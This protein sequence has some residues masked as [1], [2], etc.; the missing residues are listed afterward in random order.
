MIEKILL[1]DDDARILETF[2][3]YL[4][5]ENYTVITT[6][7]SKEAFQLYLTEQPQV[8]FTDVRMPPPDGF[9]ILQAIHA[10][11]PEAEVILITGHGDMDLAINALRAGASDFIPKPFDPD[12]VTTALYRARERLRLKHELQTANQALVQYARE[13]ETQNTELNRYNHT[14][15]Y[16]LQS[17]LHLIIGYAELLKEQYPRMPEDFQKYLNA[18]A[19]NGRRMHQIIKE[20]LLLTEARKAKEIKLTPLNMGRIVAEVKQRL[21]Y[22]IEQSHAELFLP[23]D[24]PM[25]MGY[26][27]WV[28]EVW[29]NYISN[30]IEY[31]GRPPRLQLGAT[32]QSSGLVRFW[33]RDNG[34]ELTEQERTR[35]LSALD[36]GED[37]QPA[38]RGLGLSIVRH[39]VEKLGGQVAIENNGKF[40]QG[41]TFSFTLVGLSDDH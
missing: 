34:P 28:E 36:L 13:L 26:A 6:S 11:A 1:I 29:A 30:A 7:N 41:N 19:R 35:L 31:G 38:G 22:M 39:I 24:W 32:A 15:A 8:V 37:I 25:A 20:L 4:R 9:A 27:P 5:L 10:Q 33:V 21:A 16:D 2:A 3:R 17:P 18:M 12:S 40:K 14:V 23:T